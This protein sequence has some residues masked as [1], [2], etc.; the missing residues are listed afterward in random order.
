M[1]RVENKAEKRK[2]NELELPASHTPGEPASLHD[3]NRAFGAA[4]SA[5]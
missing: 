4:W 5:T 2:G 1:M 3:V